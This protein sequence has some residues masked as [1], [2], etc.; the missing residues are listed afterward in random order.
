MCVEVFCEACKEKHG[1]MARISGLLPV[2]VASY[3]LMPYTLPVES[4]YSAVQRSVPIIFTSDKRHP[5][6]T[7]HSE[8]V[9]QCTSFLLAHHAQ[10]S[11]HSILTSTLTDTDNRCY[12]NDNHHS[13][14]NRLFSE[15]IMT[16]GLFTSFIYCFSVVVFLRFVEWIPEVPADASWLFE[17]AGSVY[18]QAWKGES[19]NR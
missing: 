7:Q 5:V 10:Y 4:V 14:G 8:I 2:R 3:M 12:S 17:M 11:Q 13:Q 15:S 16:T 18:R 9:L 19:S 1:L 6:F